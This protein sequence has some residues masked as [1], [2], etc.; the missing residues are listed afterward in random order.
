MFIYLKKSSDQCF[1]PKTS[2]STKPKPTAVKVN[3]NL[4]SFIIICKISCQHIT[5][6]MCKCQ[7]NCEA[8][9]WK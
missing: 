3:F 4:N 8:I 6:V 9:S 1:L 5:A 2:V 7:E